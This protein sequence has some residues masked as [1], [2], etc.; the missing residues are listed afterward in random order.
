MGTDPYSAN[1]PWEEISN[2][3]FKHVRLSD[4]AI[5][6]ISCGSER[7]QVQARGK[8]RQEVRQ[9]RGKAGRQA[10]KWVGSGGKWMERVEGSGGEGVSR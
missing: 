3:T 10:G 7:S 4:C 2:G 5:P 6:A 1:P 9:A 8:C